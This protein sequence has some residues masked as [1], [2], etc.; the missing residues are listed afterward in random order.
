MIF[1]EF[2]TFLWIFNNVSSRNKNMVI[3]IYLNVITTFNK[4]YNST[5]T[6]TW[7]VNCNFLNSFTFTR[8]FVI[9]KIPLF[10]LI[11]WIAFPIT[12]NIYLLNIKVISLFYLIFTFIVEIMKMF[13]FALDRKSPTANFIAFFIARIYNICWSASFLLAIEIVTWRSSSV[14]LNCKYYY[15]E[16]VK[17]S[18]K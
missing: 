4:F 5:Q 11:F 17:G 16:R 1:F 10:F 2:W 9:L 18:T 7:I 15:V 14:I 6:Q 13:L 3:R 12:V 8:F